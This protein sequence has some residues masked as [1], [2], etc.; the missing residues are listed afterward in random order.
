VAIPGAQRI[1]AGLALGTLVVEAQAQ[2]V[3]RSPHAW[4]PMPAARWFAIPGSIHNP[5]AR[6][7]AIGLIRDGAQLVESTEEIVVALNALL[8]VHADDLRGRLHVPN[9]DAF[10]MQHASGEMDQDTQCL[11]NALGY[12]PNP[13]GRVCAREPGLTASKLVSILLVME[14]EGRVVSQHGRYTRKSS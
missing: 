7:W 6:G 11:W 2:S 12:D 13:Y 9:S 14:L 4:P 8:R 10:A 1:V 5:M 3:R